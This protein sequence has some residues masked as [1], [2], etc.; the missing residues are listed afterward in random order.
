MTDFVAGT[1]LTATKLNLRA[2]GVLVGGR[3]RV[4]DDGNTTGTT[5]KAGIT[6]PALSLEA[7]SLYLVRF[8]CRY[9]GDTNGNLFGI[10]LREDS[11][12]GTVLGSRVGGTAIATAG[13]AQLEIVDGWYTTTSALPSKVFVGT[14]VRLSGA[15]VANVR[16]GSY[17]TVERMGNSGLLAT[18]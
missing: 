1:R 13:D 10:H 18:V 16:T 7:N 6:A 8:Y 2:R 17:L 14:I 12:S 5:E 4:T 15:G 3:R 9:G 11:I